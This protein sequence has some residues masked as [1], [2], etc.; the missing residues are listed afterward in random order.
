MSKWDVEM[1]DGTKRVVE[2]DRMVAR[3][4]GGIAFEDASGEGHIESFAVDEWH[5]V[6]KR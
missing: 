1:K 3:E 2:A 6:T 5:Q 4:D